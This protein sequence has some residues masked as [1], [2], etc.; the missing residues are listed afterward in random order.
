[1]ICE[2]LAKEEGLEEGQEEG[3]KRG[4]RALLRSRFGDEGLKLM[5]E[6]DAVHDDDLLEKILVQA[7]Q[8][9]SPDRLRDCW[10]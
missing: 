4:I 7:G 5:A 9:A 6:I 1:M 2:R 3:L 8:V 10:K